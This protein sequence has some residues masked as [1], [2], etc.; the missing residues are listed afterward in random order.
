MEKTL[1][2]SDDKSSDLGQA[3]LDL[4]S[5]LE[6]VIQDFEYDTGE[7]LSG[8]AE[9]RPRVRITSLRESMKNDLDELQNQVQVRIDQLEDRLSLITKVMEEKPRADSIAVNEDEPVK[10]SSVKDTVFGETSSNRKPAETITDKLLQ[11]CS[12]CGKGVD[13]VHRLAAAP[14]VFICNDCVEFC[15][16]VLLEENQQESQPKRSTPSSNQKPAEK[17]VDKLLYCSFCGKSQHEVVK[18]I[19]GPSVFIC[20]D[21][22]ELC[23]GIIFEEGQ[24]ENPPKRHPAPTSCSFC[25]KSDDEVEE[26]L[27][28]PSVSICNECVEIS[29]RIIAERKKRDVASEISNPTEPELKS[30]TEPDWDDV[31]LHCREDGPETQKPASGLFRRAKRIFGPS[32][33]EG[34]SGWAESSSKP[35]QERETRSGRMSIWVFVG[36]CC[37]GLLLGAASTVVMLYEYPDIWVIG[38]PR[39]LFSTVIALMLLMVLIG[40]LRSDLPILITLSVAALAGWYV[41]M[42]YLTSFSEFQFLRSVMSENSDLTSFLILGGLA[43]VG[44]SF[45]SRK[46]FRVCSYC[47]AGI[48]AFMGFAIAGSV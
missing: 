8:E 40:R 19:A 34:Q 46:V 44:L 6:E 28:G 47:Y 33:K 22:V 21:C 13:E 7:E 3:L 12:V 2:E 37:L 25:N 41:T 14:N 36:Y 10:K 17:I 38:L 26:I 15:S 39:I 5:Q 18:L 31:E 30:K 24:Q 9:E 45:I 42:L 43:C 27:T 23:N 11:C 1:T 35:A 20:N 29:N 32:E 48:G 16:G 4:Q